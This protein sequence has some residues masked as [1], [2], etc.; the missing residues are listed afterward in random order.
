MHLLALII[1]LALPIVRSE[2]TFTKETPLIWTETKEQWTSGSYE[3]TLSLQLETP[4]S[5]LEEKDISWCESEF[6]EKFFHPLQDLCMEAIPTERSKRSKR[7]ITAALKYVGK[8]VLGFASRLLSGDNG[9][10]DAV[11]N[12]HDRRISGLENE[13]RFLDA[14]IFSIN[15]EVSANKVNI[16]ALIVKQEELNKDTARNSVA[17]DKLNNELR[18]LETEMME[19]Q[20]DLQNFKREMSEELTKLNEAMVD[21][22]IAIKDLDEWR[23]NMDS[24]LSD[25]IKAVGSFVSYF[26]QLET[27][28]NGFSRNWRKGRLDDALFDI[29]ILSRNDTVVNEYSG[30]KPKSCRFSKLTKL[31]VFYFQKN[32]VDSG[33]TILQA[34]PF[35]LHNPIPDTDQIE[36][37]SY[38]GPQN[39]LFLSKSQCTVPFEKD[40]G[41]IYMPSA[42]D[43]HIFEKQHTF[44]KFWIKSCESDTTLYGKD[45]QIQK[46]AEKLFIYCNGQDINIYGHSQPC[47]NYVFSIHSD[48]QFHISKFGSGTLLKDQNYESRNDQLTSKINHRIF[49]NMLQINFDDISITNK[50]LSSTINHAAIWSSIIAVV[51]IL[52][53][54]AYLY[55]RHMKVQKDFE[56]FF[57]KFKLKEG[58]GIQTMVREEV[59]K[60]LSSMPDDPTDGQDPPCYASCTEKTTGNTK[61]VSVFSGPHFRFKFPNFMARFEKST[62]KE[63]SD[64]GDDLPA[65]VKE[66]IQMLGVKVM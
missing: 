3:L 24:T 59:T 35:R 12:Q 22:N 46:M 7:W 44:Q 50:C 57:S 48:E 23:K 63:I 27:Q 36:I 52:A 45:V 47:P 19:N 39:I 62:S 8:T 37:L 34:K 58:K 29:L 16:A 66:R 14:K 2:T 21:L 43:C 20:K 51:L 53:I 6:D 17:I 64:D 61:L 28:M 1:A 60:Q 11:L 15:Q 10:S 41:L 26:L 18:I 32:S 55:R 40:I 30:A 25:K 4:C 5:Y 56:R 13:I 9:K 49:P 42:E 65:D 31:A 38:K 33:I 54:A